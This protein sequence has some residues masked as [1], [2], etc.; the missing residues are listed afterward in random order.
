VLSNTATQGGLVST[1]FGGFGGTDSS[2]GVDYND[3]TLLATADDWSISNNSQGST[4]YVDIYGFTAVETHESRDTI[5]LDRF[6]GSV[7]PEVT[8]TSTDL[9]AFA[10]GSV[11]EITSSLYTV[12]GSA[13]GNLGSIATM[14]DTINNVNDGEYYIIVYNG[15]DTNA[16]AALYYARATEGDGFD[17]ADSNGATG[18]YDTDSLELLAVF[19][20]VGAN[21]LNS[22]NFADVL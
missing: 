17:F 10:S 21:T 7:A 11:F 1:D 9:R 8:T 14:L 18:G 4:T 3:G 2:T 13:F 5:Q 20:D 15:N 16:D 6:T 22:Q 19:H 12:S